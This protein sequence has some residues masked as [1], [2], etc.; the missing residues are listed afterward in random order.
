MTTTLENPLFDRDVV[1][2]RSAQ[3]M[4]ETRLP[5]DLTIV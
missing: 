5:T 4:N 1:T 2:T 3:Q